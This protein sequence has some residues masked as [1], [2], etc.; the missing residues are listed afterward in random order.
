MRQS[1]SYVKLH[2]KSILFYYIFWLDDVLL[3]KIG[4]FDL[5][6]GS[7]KKLSFRDFSANFRRQYLH[8]GILYL[9]QGHSSII[10]YWLLKL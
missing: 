1:F 5:S 10:V 9:L 6:K 7:I 8:N 3:P 4:H 2:N